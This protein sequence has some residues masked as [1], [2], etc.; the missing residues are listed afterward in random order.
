MIYSQSI[1]QTYFAC[2]SL[3]NLW[4]YIKYSQRSI[5][6]SQS[7]ANIFFGHWE[8]WDIENLKES[9]IIIKESQHILIRLIYEEF[10]LWSHTFPNEIYWDSHENI[11]QRIS[12]VLGWD[13]YMGNKIKL[14]NLE[15][16]DIICFYSSTIIWA[17]R[18]LQSTWNNLK[19]VYDYIL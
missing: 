15:K 11:T 8:K 18:W 7:I 19:Q 1:S 16:Y 9:R 12:R 5:Q 4:E 14:W 6:Y 10:R 2:S 17:C 3:E 13:A